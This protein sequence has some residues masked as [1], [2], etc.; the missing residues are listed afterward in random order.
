MRERG[1][2]ERDIDREGGGREQSCAPQIREEGRGVRQPWK[3]GRREEVALCT[4]ERE[5]A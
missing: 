4:C 1:D 2:R 5:G 3:E